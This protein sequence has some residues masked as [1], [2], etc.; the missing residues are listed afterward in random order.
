MAVDMK[1]AVTRPVDT[2]KLTS[3]RQLHFASYNDVWNDAERLAHCDVRLLGNWSLGQIFKHLA[4]SMHHAIDGA[5][6]GVPWHFR[7]FGRVFKRRILT[8]PMP[9]GIKLPA[10][11]ARHLLPGD[12]NTEEGLKLLRQA[13]DRL[14]RDGKR[15]P[16]PF[17]GSMTREE[18]NQL[19]QRHAE[20]HLSFVEPV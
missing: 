5:P 14:E 9:A 13:I 1:P 3:R 8:K 7:V 11:A 12:T 20:L 16:S 6:F 15:A 19:H 4:E 18:Y 2:G 17:L 10:D